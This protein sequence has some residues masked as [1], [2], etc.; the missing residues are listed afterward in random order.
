MNDQSI[1]KLIAYVHF[2]DDEVYLMGKVAVDQRLRPFSVFFSKSA[3]IQRKFV[4]IIV[5]KDPYFSDDAKLTKLALTE[6]TRG[7]GFKF[8]LKFEPKFDKA[9]FFK[10]MLVENDKEV[11]IMREE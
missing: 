1:N 6:P 7:K 4:E 9:I 10:F 8:D 5:S 3:S 2:Q 11:K